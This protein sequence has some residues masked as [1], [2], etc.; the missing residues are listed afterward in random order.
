MTITL[1]R[2]QL[3]RTA[4][5]SGSLFTSLG[6]S[7]AFGTSTPGRTGEIAVANN[8]S[9]INISNKDNNN[10]I[11]NI[12]NKDNNN[13]IINPIQRQLGGDQTGECDG[14]SGVQFQPAH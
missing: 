14:G 11:I 8:T 4:T 13:N 10:N 3:G 1:R 7:S 9:N 12:I 6:T 5:S 2:S